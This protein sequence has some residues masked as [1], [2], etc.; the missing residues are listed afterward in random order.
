MLGRR[1]YSKPL[2]SKEKAILKLIFHWND[3]KSSIMIDEYAVDYTILFIH[4]F[5]QAGPQSPHLRKEP[6]RSFVTEDVFSSISLDQ[7]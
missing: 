3:K 6:R 5:T 7:D 1:T 2:Y 4:V